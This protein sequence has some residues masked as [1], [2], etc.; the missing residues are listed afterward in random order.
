MRNTRMRYNHFRTL[1]FG[2]LVISMLCLL[3]I[4]ISPLH[5]ETKKEKA[6]LGLSFQNYNNIGPRLMATV[7]YKEDRSYVPVKGV[8][9]DF[10]VLYEEGEEKY[11]GTSYSLTD[12]S[13][14]FVLPEFLK[15]TVF[16]KREASYIARIENNEKFKDQE[17]E[18]TVQRSEIRLLTEVVDSIKTVSFFVGTYDSLMNLIPVADV[19]GKIFV[20]RLF[21]DLPIMKDFEVTDE[22]GFL[23]IEFPNDIPGDE[24]GNLEIIARVDDNEDFGTLVATKMVPWGTITIKNDEAIKGELWSSRKNAPIY[25]VVISVAILAIVWGII[26][27]ILI[28][29][30]Q[31]NRIGRLQHEIK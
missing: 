23:R 26:L 12:G 7:K 5:A 25:L 14:I 19:S 20:K 18:I 22:E 21:G 31:I 11:L 1:L 30:M 9:V 24:N 10:Y 27:Y 8:K 6:R 13:I 2:V 3:T 4:S 16:L 29:L 15:K 28:L 17:A